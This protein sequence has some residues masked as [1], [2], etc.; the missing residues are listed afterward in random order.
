MT[1][2]S[3]LRIV[4][5]ATEGAPFKV[6]FEPTG[7]TYDLEPGDQVSAD[8][9]VPGSGTFEIISWPGGLSVWPPGSVVTRDAAGNELHHLN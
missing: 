1:E 9:V 2:D 3:Q 8:V 6:M 5:K 4:L 7:M